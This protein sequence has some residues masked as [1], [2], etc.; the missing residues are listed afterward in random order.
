MSEVLKFSFTQLKSPLSLISLITPLTRSIIC[1]TSSVPILT[2]AAPNEPMSL[3]MVFGNEPSNSLTTRANNA[4]IK[5]ATMPSQF[6]CA[7][8]VDKLSITVTTQSNKALTNVP[9]SNPAIKSPIPTIILLM[10]LESSS[11]KAAQFIDAKLSFK[12]VLIALNISN[13]H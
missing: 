4:S 8:S 3:E 11:T 1:F 13:T 7:T 9:Q 5:P 6:I 12:V 2:T 10:P